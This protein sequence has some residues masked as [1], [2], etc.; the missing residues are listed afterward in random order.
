MRTAATR[1]H[2]AMCKSRVQNFHGRWF[3]ALLRM[4]IIIVLEKHPE[5]TGGYAKGEY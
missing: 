3:F 5:E 2:P 1:K 4:H